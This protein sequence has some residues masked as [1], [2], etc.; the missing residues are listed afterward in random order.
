LHAVFFVLAKILG[1]GVKMELDWYIKCMPFFFSPAEDYMFFFYE[2]RAKTKKCFCF[3]KYDFC[4]I[5][6]Q[7]FCFLC[8]IFVRFSEQFPPKNFSAVH[9]LEKSDMGNMYNT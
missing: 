8:L 5:F 4:I 9:L 7:K 6:L 1:D 2:N 3:K